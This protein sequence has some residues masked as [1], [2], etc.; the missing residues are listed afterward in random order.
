VQSVLRSLTPAESRGA[1]IVTA[2]DFS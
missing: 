1:V 2:L